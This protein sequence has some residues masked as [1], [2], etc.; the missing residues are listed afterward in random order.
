M[1]YLLQ[2][3][4]SENQWK[5][6]VR[7]NIIISQSQ[8]IKTL[9]LI[10]LK[11]ILKT[12]YNYLNFVNNLKFKHIDSFLYFFLHLFNV[13]VQVFLSACTYVYDM[14]VVQG[15]QKSVLAI[16]EFLVLWAIWE[17]CQAPPLEHSFLLTA[18]PPLETP[19]TFVVLSKSVIFPQS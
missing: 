2:S 4:N 12:L 14:P 15:G 13:C 8:D 11:E 5:Q 6:K 3:N 9:V 7:S 19:S 10:I 16:L 17:P 1:L 18:E